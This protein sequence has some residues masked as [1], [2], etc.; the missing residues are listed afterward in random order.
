MIY[1][2]CTRK[3]CELRQPSLSCSTNVRP[4]S[5]FSAR[6]VETRRARDAR[7]SSDWKIKKRKRLQKD[8]TEN[9]T[10]IK[11]STVVQRA[12]IALP[13]YVFYFYL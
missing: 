9:I 3:P 7:P 11:V 10:T 6:R 1:V 2:R 5:V 8:I 13:V 4:F 12:Q